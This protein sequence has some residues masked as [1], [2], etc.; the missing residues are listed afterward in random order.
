MTTRTRKTAISASHAMTS[1]MAIL[2]YAAVAL[3]EALVEV[4]RRTAAFLEAGFL[5]PDFRA[6]V[7]VV[8]IFIRP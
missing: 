6:V 2:P 4:E 8:A 1:G 3:A 5:E 7:L